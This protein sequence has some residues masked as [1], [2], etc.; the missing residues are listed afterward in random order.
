MTVKP[1]DDFYKYLLSQ[2]LTVFNLKVSYP[3]LFNR[4]NKTL[5]ID[6]TGIAADNLI[7]THPIILIQNNQASLTTCHENDGLGSGD[8][9]I[10]IYALGRNADINTEFLQIGY[11]KGINE[12][13]LLSDKTG[14]GNILDINIDNQLLFSP[15]ANPTFSK[16]LI[17][18]STGTDQ[19]DLRLNNSTDNIEMGVDNVGDGF[20]NLG[21][22]TG[23]LNLNETINIT[24]DTNSTN[25]LDGCAR[26]AGGIGVAKTIIGNKI[27]A[28]Y[29]G[30]D[31]ISSN[32]TMSIN[33][34]TDAATD[35]LTGS[36]VTKGGIACDKIIRS[37]GLSVGQ[38][39]T[40]SITTGYALANNL[41]VLNNLSQTFTTTTS[42]YL[43]Y[44]EFESQINPT[45]VQLL[46]SLSFPGGLPPSGT[47]IETS[48]LFTQVVGGL[49]TQ[50][51]RINFN[52]TSFLSPSTQYGIIVAKSNGDVS[53]NPGGHYAG[54]NLWY[55][56]NVQ[57]GTCLT[58]SVHVQNV[59]GQT[60]TSISTD[61]TLAANSDT[62]LCTQKAIKTYVASQ[63]PTITAPLTLTSNAGLQL[64]LAY[65]V[66]N[67]TSFTTGATGI[68]NISST[69]ANVEINS[70]NK[71]IINNVTDTTS[72]NTGGLQ[73]LGGLGVEKSITFGTNLFMD[74]STVLY[75]EA[76]PQIVT[77]V[78]GPTL[79]Q[80][81]C[82]CAYYFQ[83]TSNNSLGFN[84]DIPHDWKTESTLYFHIHWHTGN[85]DAGDITWY[86]QYTT[87]IPGGTINGSG[88]TGTIYNIA[89]PGTLKATVTELL[90][91]SMTGI[92]SMNAIVS[93]TITRAGGSDTYNDPVRLTGFGCHYIADKWGSTNK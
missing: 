47:L 50:N 13:L 41:V 78:G 75:K 79:T 1:T 52:G 6:P 90:A 77:V 55:G 68:M 85:N 3:L 23:M 32:G 39:I 35:F 73:L 31:G 58:F 26:F 14:S 43:S 16:G 66:G 93:G 9:L 91:L 88:T 83:G 18:N 48:T 56:N 42:G 22:V 4:I 11:T 71:L 24:D 62:I 49:L 53:E 69:G 33:N 29:A 21:S 89:N 10:K 82:V 12:Y 84:F 37:M 67:Y 63:T 59:T 25:S 30:T 17:I 87:Y 54:G 86:I 65:D 7:S 92:T 70:T 40:T 51:C 44:I 61:G 57:V 76:W 36:I 20:I 2:N 19:L 74:S 46:G 27:V 64:K 15:I 8:N 34:V 45:S 80:S 5:S 28:E 72:K 38:N 60:I 81:G